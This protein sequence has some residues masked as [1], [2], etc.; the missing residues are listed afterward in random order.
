ME[1]TFQKKKKKKSGS[2][3][4]EIKAIDQPSKVK[5]FFL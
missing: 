4:E 5:T 2:K 3:K 1:W